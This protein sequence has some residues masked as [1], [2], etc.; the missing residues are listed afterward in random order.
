M[1]TRISA[2]NGYLL[3]AILLSVIWVTGKPALAVVHIES[4]ALSGQVAPGTDELFDVFGYPMIDDTGHVAF[5]AITPGFN[6]GL[7]YE[8]AGTLSLVAYEGMDAPGTDG[9]FTFLDTLTLNGAGQIGFGGSLI[10]GVGDVTAFNNSGV[11]TYGAGGLGLVA[12]KGN[13]APGASGAYFGSLNVPLFFNDVG[14][15]AFAGDMTSGEVIETHAIGRGICYGTQGSLTLVAGSGLAAPGASVDEYFGDA[16]DIGGLNDNGVI[17]FKANLDGPNVTVENESGIW[18]GFAGSLNL[19]AREGDTAPGAGGGCYDFLSARPRINNAGHIAFGGSLVAGTGDVTA[20][21]NAGI[22]SDR[23]GSLQLI[24]RKGDLVPGL[25]GEEFDTF[26]RILINGSDEICFLGL[27]TGPGVTYS[28]NEGIWCERTDGLQLIA[29]EGS[30]AAGTAGVFS[31]LDSQ[32]GSLAMNGVGQVVFLAMLQGGVGGI[33]VD[34]DQGLW[35][36]DTNGQL[37]LVVR[38]GDVID[39][40]SNPLIDDYRTIK[41]IILGLPQSGGEDGLASPISDAGQIAFWLTF[42]DDT[43]G[44]FVAMVPEPGSVGLMML[45]CAG[46]TGRRW[47]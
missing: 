5:R 21:N 17:T 29:R 15:L 38:E 18:S 25:S 36:T 22:W 35:A 3:I 37:I 26:G 9:Q 16:F 10:P 20:D 11:W 31:S 27:V 41:S 14:Q 40:N 2:G 47:V 4:R 30:A 12:R 46:L 44:I 33:T 39:V 43:S 28:N 23:S 42:T 32:A 13:V 1:K 7:W 24:A 8:E 19:V 6:R 34:N 45:G